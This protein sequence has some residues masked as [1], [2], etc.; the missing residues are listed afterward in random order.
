MDTDTVGQK[1]FSS[2][3]L[4]VSCESSSLSN[5]SSSKTEFPPL[6]TL[7]CIVICPSN[8]HIDACSSTTCAWVCEY[9][10]RRY[11]LHVS[12]TFFNFPD[13][14]SIRIQAPRRG[15]YFLSPLFQTSTPYSPCT[16]SQTHRYPLLNFPRFPQ[17]PLD[18]H[19]L[20]VLYVHLD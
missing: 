19:P 5:S 15:V 9:P 11:P 18:T 1:R 17:H 6:T 20:I 10:H 3:F 4:C 16:Y 8:P 14:Q 2:L 7:H 12:S 13:F